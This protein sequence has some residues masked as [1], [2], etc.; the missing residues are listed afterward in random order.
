MPTQ[1]CVSAFHSKRVDADK[2]EV[3]VRSPFKEWSHTKAWCLTEYV[4]CWSLYPA[5]MAGKAFVPFFGHDYA[6]FWLLIEVVVD[7]VPQEEPTEGFDMK[8]ICSGQCSDL[9]R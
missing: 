9:W 3:G 4:R 6:G 2:A 5:D 8:R 7:F 1:A